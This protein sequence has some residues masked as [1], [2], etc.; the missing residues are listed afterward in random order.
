[1]KALTLSSKYYIFYCLNTSDDF[2]YWLFK[3]LFQIC[4]S[5]R[6]A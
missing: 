1:M 2:L 5:V 6:A 3:P 4:G